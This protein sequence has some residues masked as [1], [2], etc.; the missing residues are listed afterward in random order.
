MYKYIGWSANVDIKLS[1]NG[2]L[3][4]HVLASNNNLMTVAP[5]T[6]PN[7]VSQNCRIMIALREYILRF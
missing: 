4:F 5:T 6:V 2:G 3:T 1:T 7:L